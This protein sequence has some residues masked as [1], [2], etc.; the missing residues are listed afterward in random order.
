VYVGSQ[1]RRLPPAY[2]PAAN[3]SVLFALN[4]DIYTADPRSGEST[5][6]VSGPEA[7][8]APVYSLDGTRFAFARKPLA[9]STVG[10]LFVAHADGSGVV[11]VTSE[12]MNELSDW[13]FAPD[14]R[15]IVAFAR[16]DEGKAIVVIPSDGTGKPRIF[17]VFATDDDG[18]PQYRPDGSEIM[19][20]GADPKSVNRGVYGLDPMTGGVRTIVPPSSGTMDIYGASWSP[21]GTRV[22]YGVHDTT[23]KTISTRTHIVNVDGTGDF[24]VDTHPDTIADGGVAWSNDGTRLIVTRFYSDDGSIPARSAI[25]PVDRSSVGIEIACPPKAPADDC[26]ADW[27]WSPDDTQLIG[28]LDRVTGQFLADPNTGEIRAAPWMAGG[29]PVWQRLAK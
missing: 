24:A 13:S 18:P 4:G 21:D 19:F 15:S 5:A 1:Q 25:V 3:G 22:A 23:A 11:Q 29:R 6:I 12:S 17:P 20:I 10:V 27:Q 9:G 8:V 2:G 26:S 7:D 14:G 28:T 16:N